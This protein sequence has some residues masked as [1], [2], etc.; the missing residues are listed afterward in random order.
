MTISRFRVD[1][2]LKF[3]TSHETQEYPGIINNITIHL[4]YLS[5]ARYELITDQRKM[6]ASTLEG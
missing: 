2:H 4:M 5:V 3:M 6:G 1:P